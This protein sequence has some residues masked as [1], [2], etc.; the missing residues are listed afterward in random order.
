MGQGATNL[1]NSEQIMKNPQMKYI[2]V[3]SLHEDE[4]HTDA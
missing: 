4:Q 2:L 3:F 1:W